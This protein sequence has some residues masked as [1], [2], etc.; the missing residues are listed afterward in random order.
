MYTNTF[1]LSGMQVD[2]SMKHM[3]HKLVELQQREDTLAETFVNRVTRLRELQLIEAQQS[4]T[5]AMSAAEH[6]TAAK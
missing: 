6:A 1:S 4:Y 2:S 3:E 5:A